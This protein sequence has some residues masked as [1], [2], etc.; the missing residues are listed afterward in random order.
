MCSSLFV[1][2]VCLVVVVGFFLCGVV[3]VCFVLGL[4]CFRVVVFC[5]FLGEG[6][7]VCFVMF[8]FEFV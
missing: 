6:G 7:F 1:I 5:G 8:L 2:V 4:F 3:V